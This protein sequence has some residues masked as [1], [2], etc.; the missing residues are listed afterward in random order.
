MGNAEEF[1]S[2]EGDK[3]EDSS[4]LNASHYIG[5]VRPLK[6]IVKCCNRGVVQ[7]TGSKQSLHTNIEGFAA[8]QK[9]AFLYR[10]ANA[11]LI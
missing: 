6:H 2:K 4:L 10:G 3:R 9:R 1:N 8:I 11:L 7:R 5:G